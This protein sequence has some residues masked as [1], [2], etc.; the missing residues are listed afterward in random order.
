MRETLGLG[1]VPHAPV[2]ADDSA[3]TAE[4]RAVAVSV[5]ANDTD[6]NGDPLM[7]VGV[8]QGAHGSVVNNGDGTVTYAPA[9]GSVGTDGFTYTA[10]DGRGGSDVAAVV[11]IVERPQSAD[12]GKASGQGAVSGGSALS[13]H[14]NARSVDGVANGRLNCDGALGLKGTVRS[15]R[16]SGRSAELGASARWP[17][18]A[19]SALKS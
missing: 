11:L 15:M 12:E 18:A 17:T 7:V 2:A 6:A 13:F 14:L 8:T 3:E 4:N 9:A 16:L 10:A 19:R 5:L 1:Q